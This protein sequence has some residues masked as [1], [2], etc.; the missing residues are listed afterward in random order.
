MMWR[1]EL[2]ELTWA[3]RSAWPAQ[4]AIRRAEM[5]N[6]YDLAMCSGSG[7][8]D[9]LHADIENAYRPCPQIESFNN[10]LLLLLLNLRNLDRILKKSS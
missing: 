5:T 8:N 3:K 4:K 9:D 1:A 2:T 6:A 10:S 7:V